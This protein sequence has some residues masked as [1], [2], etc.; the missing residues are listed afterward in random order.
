MPEPLSSLICIAGIDKPF[1][2][3]EADF[4]GGGAK[5]RC[6]QSQGFASDPAGGLVDKM[7]IIRLPRFG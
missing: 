3:L 7:G 5:P 6:L 4:S 2:S 1:R